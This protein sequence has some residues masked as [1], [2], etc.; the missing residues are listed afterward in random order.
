MHFVGGDGG[1]GYYPAFDPAVVVRYL[2]AASRGDTE[3]RLSGSMVLIVL[4]T[5]VNFYGSVR[6]GCQFHI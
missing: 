2:F 5:A 3:L 6:H 1:V 4:S